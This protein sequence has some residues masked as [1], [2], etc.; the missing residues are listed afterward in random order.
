M[1]SSLLIT[2]RY[3]IE[4]KKLEG[5]TE[6]GLTKVAE[7]TPRSRNVN[8]RVRVL[9]I[10]EP[11]VVFSRVT[12]EKHRVAEALVGDDSGVVLMSLWNDTIDEVEVNETYDIK[13]ARVTLFNNTIRLSLGR[14]GKMDK[15]SEEIPD[16][17][18]NRDNNMSLRRFERRVRRW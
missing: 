9:E 14:N 6:T 11:K 7:L 5:S 3:N 15:S 4:L 16:E 13:N 12:G 8:L 17:S 2:R 1:R 18:I 10:N